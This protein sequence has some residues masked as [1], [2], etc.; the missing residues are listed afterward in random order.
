MSNDYYNWS[1]GALVKYTLA[2]TAALANQFAGITAGFNKLPDADILRENRHLYIV[3]GGTANAL[4]GTMPH[5][6]LSAYVA[7]LTVN[8]KIAV[9]NTGPVTLNIDGLGVKQVLN[10]GGG[11]LG[12]NDLVADAVVSMKYNGTAF[13]VDSTA[14]AASVASATAVA[15]AAA[16]SS[17]ASA[18]AASAVTAAASAASVGFTLSSASILTNK[19]INLT[20]NTLVATLAQINAAVSDADLVSLAGS[21]TLTNKTINLTSNTLVATLAQINAAVSDADLVSLAG[22][23]TLTN[24]TFGNQTVFTHPASST[25]GAVIIRDAAGDPGGGYL[26]WTNNARSTQYGYIRGVNGSFHFSGNIQPVTDNAASCGL[27]GSRWATV[28]A[29]TGTIN[30]SDERLK[31]WR[32][33]L[34]PAELAAARR[35]ASE[36]GAYQWRDAIEKKLADGTEA[37]FHIGVRAQRVF[38]IMDEYWLDWRRYGWCCFDKWDAEYEADGETLIRPAGEMYAIR[39]DELSFFLIAAQEQRL[40]A[41]EATASRS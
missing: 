22:S 33:K 6:A 35:I 38:S 4:T 12:A 3:A 24:K 1:S 39:P 37:R 11:A 36:I 19:T 25:T 29:A 21:E 18:A 27:V 34:S 16:A 41:L 13:T 14:S 28:Y 32:G 7:G 17:S 30:T 23:E 26:Q 5:T 10:V 15:A 31:V 20:S 9:N 2:R 8:V 40:L